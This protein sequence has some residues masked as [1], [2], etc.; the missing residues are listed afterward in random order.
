MTTGVGT[1]LTMGYD[2]LRR[3]TSVTGG[4]VTRQYTYRDIDSTKTTMQVASVTSGGQQYGYPYD[5]MGNIATYSAPDGEVTIYTYDNKGQLLKATGNTTY[6]YT[7]DGAGN[8][9]TA[10]DGTATHSYTYG[11]ASWKDLLT[12]F[13]GQAITYD[14]IGNPTSYFNGTRWN[15]TWVI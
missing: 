5:S 2:G 10:S 7:Y 15:F 3:L 13:D 14:A 1:T 9:L 6:T 12:A 4:P 11:D 8:I